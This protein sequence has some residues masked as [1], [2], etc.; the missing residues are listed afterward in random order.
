MMWARTVLCELDSGGTLGLV[1]HR[2]GWYL[3]ACRVNEAVCDVV[4]SLHCG[5]TALIVDELTTASIMSQR[6]V[7]GTWGTVQA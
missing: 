1:G 7:A 2:A 4:H 3:N 6:A 5:A